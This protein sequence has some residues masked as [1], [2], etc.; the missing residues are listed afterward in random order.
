MLITL[1]YANQHDYYAI[2]ILIQSRNRLVLGP[3]WWSTRSLVNIIVMFRSAFPDCKA[4][5]NSI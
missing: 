3:E 2:I 1:S 5:R 4:V